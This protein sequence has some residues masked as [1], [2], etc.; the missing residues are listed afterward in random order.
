MKTFTHITSSVPATISIN[1]QK[2]YQLTTP[3]FS[4]IDILHKP[5]IY[6]SFFPKESYYLP[7]T[8]KTG[9]ENLENV[10]IIP[11]TNNNF[12][13]VY[14]PSK[15]MCCNNETILYEKNIDGMYIKITSNEKTFLN[16]TSSIKGELL[17]KITP[18]IITIN[19]EINNYIYIK[20]I[21][22][23]NSFYAIVLHNQS[24]LIEGVFDIIEEENK[25]IKFLKFTNDLSEHGIVNIFDKK[26]LG[27]DTYSVYKNNKPTTTSNPTLIP[28]AFLES[29][30]VGD[31][32][33]AKYYL[34]DNFISNEHITSYF[35]KIQNIYL[36]TYNNDKINYTIHAD[37][38]FKSYNFE[39][40]NGKITDIEEV[41]F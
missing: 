11:Y 28:M 2:T 3:G 12:E 6:V 40:E 13:I 19:D 41:K 4:W 8:I 22:K 33:L 27:V 15:M 26:T 7:A 21:T 18:D 23:N 29:I 30:K 24:I 34:R 38:I 16:I 9:N 17:N 32:T 1:G 36:N 20:A 25:T 14:T 31:M 10:N 39:I 37:N 5:E 35:G